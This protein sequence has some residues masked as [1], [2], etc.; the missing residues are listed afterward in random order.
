MTV[1][2]LIKQLSELPQDAAVVVW[3]EAFGYIEADRVS[4]DQDKTRVFI[5]EDVE[6]E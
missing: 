2:E 3:S 5:E 4:I 6:C 1:K